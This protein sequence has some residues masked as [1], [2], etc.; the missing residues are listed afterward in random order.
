AREHIRC[1]WHELSDYTLKNLPQDAVVLSTGD[2]MLSG[3]GRFAS[4]N[5]TIIP[6]ISSLQLACAR[7]RIEFGSVSVVNA[8]ARDIQDAKELMLRELGAGKIVF[9]LPDAIFGAVEAAGFLRSKGLRYRIAVLENLSYA[10]ER[11]EIGDAE[12]PPAARNGM[13]CMVIGD[14]EP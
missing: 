9:M 6:G 1:E 3:L 5:D 12:K 2:P 10:D 14:F 4:R 7:L 8:H 13:Y 11:I